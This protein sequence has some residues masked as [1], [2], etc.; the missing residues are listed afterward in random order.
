MSSWLYDYEN[1]KNHY[2]IANQLKLIELSTKWYNAKS[3]KERNSLELMMRSIKINEKD[4][5]RN[6]SEDALNALF[7]GGILTEVIF[8]AGNFSEEELM[9]TVSNYEGE[10]EKY[11]YACLGL[12]KKA[13]PGNVRVF[14]VEGSINERIS[15]GRNG[16]VVIQ[17]EK[18]TLFVN[19]GDEKRAEEFLA[20]RL[21]QGINDAKI[22]SFEVS[23]SF[24]N[25]IKS[26]AV[27]ESEASKFPNRPILV[28]ITKAENQFGLRPEQIK[29]LKN[30]I[31][32]NSGKIIKP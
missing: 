23:E 18:N 25:K 30:E 13:S 11:V 32:K 17:S 1:D 8:R 27:L 2:S 10:K 31:I 22:K 26:E 28:D 14:R 16:E 4:D 19:F 24:L 21:S 9:D 15:I 6:F 29:G 7:G 12:S 5:F 20:K 3:E